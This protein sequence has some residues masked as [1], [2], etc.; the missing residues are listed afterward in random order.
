[1]SLYRIY[2]LTLNR[3]QSIRYSI[4][5]LWHYKNN[6]NTMKK[7]HSGKN[8]L[9]RQTRLIYGKYPWQELSK[10]LP[11]PGVVLIPCT[12]SLS[13]QTPSG[14]GQRIIRDT[15]TCGTVKLEMY[16]NGRSAVFLVIYPS[17]LRST[18]HVN[19]YI[20][21]QVSSRPGLTLS[22]NIAVLMCFLSGVWNIM[23]T[24]ISRG[25]TPAEPCRGRPGQIYSELL[26]VF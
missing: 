23:V 6:K 2:V 19:T 15:I 26:Y 11:C 21:G 10:T 13:N 17:P 16:G 20:D 24:L 12:V 22:W 8:K 14:P 3:E 5:P 9:L 18:V 7:R 4:R 1:M 25:R